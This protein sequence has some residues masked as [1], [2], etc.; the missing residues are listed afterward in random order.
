MFDTDRD[1]F[2]SV[3]DA[4]NRG[5]QA[6][7]NVPL[8]QQERADRREGFEREDAVRAEGREQQLTDEA[9]RERLEDLQQ[10][11]E[12]MASLDETNPEDQDDIELAKEAI[13]TILSEL[14]M[15]GQE[16]IASLGRGSVTTERRNTTQAQVQGPTP[17][18]EGTGQSLDPK[19]SATV[20]QRR[21]VPTGQ[22]IAEVGAGAA[23]AERRRGIE[24][25]ER[26]FEHQEFMTRL[27]FELEGISRE[28]EQ[29]FNTLM[30]EAQRAHE[31]DQQTADIK[32]RMKELL[33]R[34]GHDV[35]ENALNR[36]LD[37]YLQEQQIAAD[38]AQYTF[39]GDA[40]ANQR[41]FNNLWN[42]ASGLLREGENGASGADVDA[43]VVS[44]KQHRA[45]NTLSES[46]VLALATQ[47]ETTTGL[48][49]EEI[50]GTRAARQ[51]TEVEIEARQAEVDLSQWQTSRLKTTAK[52]EDQQAITSGA[53]E[54][55]ER[56]D[57]GTLATYR[58]IAEGGIE[59][60][61]SQEQVDA[62]QALNFEILE[63]RA[64]EVRSNTEEFTRLAME[65]AKLLLDSKM[66]DRAGVRLAFSQSVA[67][68]FETQEEAEAYLDSLKPSDLAAL[69]LDTPEGKQAFLSQVDYA[70][71]LRERGEWAAKLDAMKAAPVDSDE[72]EERFVF[73]AE[74]ADIPAD[75]ARQ[76]AK[77]L[78][79]IV[80]MEDDELEARIA[81]LAAEAALLHAKAG[82]VAGGAGGAAF[83]EKVAGL[84]TL[85]DSARYEA[86]LACAPV[87]TLGE[88]PR[89][90]QAACDLARGK[91][92]YW[93]NALSGVLATGG[94]LFPEGPEQEDPI[95]LTREAV[96]AGAAHDDIPAQVWIDNP[97]LEE[98]LFPDVVAERR[99]A[100][101][102]R[103]RSAGSVFTETNERLEAQNRA[104]ASVFQG[105]ARFWTNSDAP[106]HID[107]D[108]WT[109]H[110][111][112]A[113]IGPLIQNYTRGHRDGND[114]AKAQAKRQIEAIAA[115]RR[116]RPGVVETMLIEHIRD[117]SP[118]IDQWGRQ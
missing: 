69:G 101:A 94:V 104:V 2:A 108:R 77:G 55:A 103:D 117:I 21:T 111:D 102:P 60:G 84:N 109:T 87:D 64:E 78:R 42:Q 91:V 107:R 14:D 68:V 92:N 62:A 3:V 76:I 22:A 8:A 97:N 15:T 99:R 24:A 10:L 57:I 40:E 61:Y 5:G 33:K 44:L 106:T 16:A 32:S 70:Q 37:K 73:T 19:A 46:Q 34:L 11:Y 56:G 17:T 75:V 96:S 79:R 112:E 98:E 51:L 26:Q 105:F 43:F 90:D 86:Q 118:T 88:E 36:E 39:V 110:V 54:A 45:N 115:E 74:L 65:E 59:A 18:V 31:N 89:V 114:A 53:F 30:A 47:A 20:T 80:G 25:E 100:S 13:S 95:E 72:W 7:A 4:L 28:D 35:S 12:Y 58:A 29:A 41:L 67:S 27:G 48:K 81:N 38:K 71:V 1:P 23:Q 82:D 66:V 83:K 9:R 116:I 93:Q 63:N 50:L 113:G 52:V 85:L 6:H 49:A